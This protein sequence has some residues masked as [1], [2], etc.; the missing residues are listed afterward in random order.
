MDK[1]T[2]PA[3][4]TPSAAV[5]PQL[6]AP[7][8]LTANA[9]ALARE[10]TWFS[11]MVN[12]RL[13]EYFPDQTGLPEPDQ[14]PAPMPAKTAEKEVREQSWTQRLFQRRSSL[15]MLSTPPVRKVPVIVTMAPAVNKPDEL[16][17][18]APDLT[19]DPSVYAEL[20]NYYKL[21]T[22]ERMI[23]ILALIP[24]VQPHLL[25]VFLS[26]N[27]SLGRGYTEFGGVKSNRHSGF[28]PTIETALFLLAGN[29]LTERFRSYR[30][31]EPDHVFFAHNILTLDQSSGDDPFYSS[32]LGISD[33][34]TDFFTAGN[35]RK[36][37]FSLEFPAKRLETRSEW[38]DLV[39]DDFTAKQLDELRIWLEHGRTLYEDWGMGKKLK[40]GYKALFHGPPGTGKTMTAALL[41]KQ[42]G[43]DVYRIDLSMVISKFIGETEKNL[44][45]VFKKAEN[46][47]WIL[48]FDEAD[49][50]F[51]KRTAIS[52]SHDKYA[53]Q[54]IA[55]LLQRLEDYP[56]LVI[57]ASN[58]RNNVDEAF[59]RRLNAIIHFQK[60]QPRERLRLW[61]NAFSSQSKPP[62]RDDLGRI[63]QQYDLS[64]GS[65]M[66]VVHY[67]SLMSLNR[68][69]DVITVD[70][71]VQGIKKEYRKEGRT[72]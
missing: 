32:V 50:L 15:P 52:D 9:S 38:S 27:K 64:G 6:P 72:L 66:N 55:Y 17:V 61:T 28:I 39:V 67:A 51:G 31:F 62:G 13:K 5:P 69:D 53:N 44:E 18:P 35:Y 12:G 57:L 26:V 45:K 8:R 63:A 16:P 58:M 48:F 22:D 34:Y 49:A 33:E 3:V 59:T 7:D 36:P 25:D 10:I 70:D 60:P 41:G 30:L 4:N 14:M 21:S 11:A 29:D 68:K 24:E 71:L 47:N 20:V 2:S 46:K 1:D 42:Y 23:L 56:G 65:I 54:E 37:A 43:L 19:N 40:P